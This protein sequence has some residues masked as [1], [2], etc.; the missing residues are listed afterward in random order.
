MCTQYSTASRHWILFLC[1]RSTTLN[2]YFLCVY[3]SMSD[4]QWKVRDRETEYGRIQIFVINFKC[5]VACSL[6]IRFWLFLLRWKIVLEKK[7]VFM[8]HVAEKYANIAQFVA[9]LLTCTQHTLTLTHDHRQATFSIINQSSA[10]KLWKLHKY[11]FR[12][13]ANINWLANCSVRIH[14]SFKIIIES[15]ATHGAKGANNHE[16]KKKERKKRKFNEMG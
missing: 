14:L 13:D 11:K 6:T 12:F 10:F 2:V 7:S 16:M 1:V 9:H 5:L 4:V 8:S 15:Y 3:L